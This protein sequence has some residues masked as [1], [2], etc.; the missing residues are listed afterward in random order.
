MNLELHDIR[1]SPDD[2]RY[3][4]APFELSDQFNGDWWD[5]PPYLTDDPHFVVARAQ[6]IEV[7]R[8]ELDHD[9]RGSLHVGAPDLGASALE[10]Q[11]VEV[12]AS[13]RRQGIGAEVVHR[14]AAAYPDRRLLAMSEGADE[15]WASLRWERYD[16]WDGPIQYRPLFIRP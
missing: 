8:V 11:F 10:I 3:V 2:D 1:R 12:A 9:F 7:A 5:S 16:Y 13:H 6:G 14:L 15:F 4:W